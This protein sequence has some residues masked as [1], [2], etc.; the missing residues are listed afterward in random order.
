M[1]S[2]SPSRVAQQGFT[3]LE[4]LTV[5][6][7]IGLLVGVL[8]LNVSNQGD[9]RQLVTH[10]ERLMLQ[11][12][13]ARQKSTISN[14]V[15]GIALN[16]DRYEFTRFVND[17]EW[18]LVEDNSFHN[19]TLPVNIFLE[20]RLLAGTERSRRSKT[21]RVPDLLIFPSG[22][23]TPFEATFRHHA[24]GETVFV[25]SDGLQRSLVSSTPYKKVTENDDAST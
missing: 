14:E 1:R 5:L 2:N 23:M 22:D 20:N 19:T 17:V 6:V 13:L 21:Q 4:L 18:Q 7:I 11:I 25:F 10:A 9:R 24:L 15:W 3:L 16:R 8:V 12:E